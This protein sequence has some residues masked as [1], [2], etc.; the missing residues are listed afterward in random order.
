MEGINL[1]LAIDQNS[2]YKIYII[3]D[4][5]IR[6]TNQVKFH[7]SYFPMKEAAMRRM[8]RIADDAIETED[9]LPPEEG[10]Y[11]VSYDLQLL[12]LVWKLGSRWRSTTGPQEC[13]H[14]FQEIFLDAES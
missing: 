13:I 14:A 4:K 10:T 11:L 1:G 7:E 12:E 8:P 6:I 5:T 3:K 9:A 2:A